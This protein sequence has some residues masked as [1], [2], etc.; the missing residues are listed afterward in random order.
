LLSRAE[1]SQRRCTQV[2]MQRAP[3]VCAVLALFPWG[4][5]ESDGTFNAHIARARFGVLGGTGTGFWSARGGPAPHRNEHERLRAG[6]GFEHLDGH[7]L[8]CASGHLSDEEGWRLPPALIPYRDFSGAGM[9]RVP[10]LVTGL[11]D[12]V[13]DWASWYAWRGLPFGSPAALLMHYPLTVYHLLTSVLGVIDP[14]AGKGDKTRK[15]CVHL[16]GVEVELNFLPIFSELALLLPHH[17]ITLVLFGPSVHYLL[18]PRPPPSSSPLL[19]SLAPAFTY[20][21]PAALGSSLLTIHLRG[22]APHWSQADISSI[23]GQEPDA[24]V[25]CNAGI[26]AYGAWRGAV[27]AARDRRIPFAVT[28]YT[29]A[30]AACLDADTTMLLVEAGPAT[31]EPSAAKL[32]PLNPFHRPGQRWL[33]RCRVPNVVNGF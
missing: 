2:Y 14:R 26:A 30:E 16:L 17:D 23:P 27:A 9:T 18:H 20:T 22:A 15:V 7:D 1:R 8:L 32:G 28:E 25:A 19:T 10:P 21:S 5:L 4:R 12:G 13:H 31:A 3:A 33:A 24:L 29:E 6:F 11:V